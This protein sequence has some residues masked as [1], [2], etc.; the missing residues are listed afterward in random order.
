M[1]AD[2]IWLQQLANIGKQTQFGIAPSHGKKIVIE[3]SSPNT[4]KPLHLGHLRNNFLGHA[5]AEILKAVGYE[6]Y[7]V[8]LINDR[9]IHICKSMI[10]YQK[11][12]QQ[13]TPT[14]ANMKGDHFVGHYYVK[15]ETIY[16]QQIAANIAEGFTPEQARQKAPI[17]LEAQEM[18]QK[19][20]KG[21][22]QVLALWEKMNHWV[23]QGFS[24]TYAQLGI[25]FDRTYYE[26]KTYLLGKKIV[27]EGLKKNIFYQKQD[28]SI[29]A[30]MTTTGLDHKLL[31]RPDGTSVYITQD[32]G[33]AALRYQDYHFDQSI[34]VVGN[35]QNYH[36]SLLFKLLHQLG[37]TYA[38]NMHHLS[39]GMVDL[40]TGKMKS[41]E[42]NVV[43]ADKLIE[44][45]TEIAAKHTKNL[46]KID[47]F[48]QKKQQQLYHILAMGALKY[49]LLRV[50][51]K[52]NILFD[53][54]ASINF[55]GNTG[56]FIQYTYARISAIIKNAE[57]MNITHKN[58]I[59][60]QQIIL[61]S[62]ERAIIILLYQFP[63]KLQEAAKT[64]SPAIIAQYAYDLAKTYN[65]LY[66]SLPILHAK[67]PSLQAMRIYLS[68]TV[69]KILHQSM[70]LLG[71]V[72]PVRM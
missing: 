58:I 32:L 46:G 50:E 60:N 51:A 66:A 59:L 5:M 16:K 6:V 22:K 17:L 28:G 30:D 1:I 12:G 49:F 8:N 2:T 38:T 19:W 67:T 35:E 9:G 70:Q 15:F 7:K 11:F 18:L 71:I 69:A 45:M 39:Y 26:S 72:L 52:K 68:A 31:L 40:P 25:T 20:E 62:I 29:W 43:D 55:Q 53:P 42:G 48:T 34:Y 10:A 57:K 36:F 54:Q 23:Y 27:Q 3:F 61:K 63:E 4:N 14:T 47:N 24:T 64:Y 21:D 41:R 65:H 13:A 33:V 56:P 44:D 37:H